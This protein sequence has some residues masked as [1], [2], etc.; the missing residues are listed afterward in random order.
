MS[1][2]NGEN[3]KVLVTGGCGF[4]GSH[5]CEYY[6]NRGDSVIAYDS[7]TKYELERVGYGVDAS[8][9]YNWNF[10]EKLGVTMVKE[11]I[12]D[13]ETLLEH[14]QGVD[15]IIHTAAQPAMTISEEDPEL[16]FSTNVRG[17]FNVLK[18]ARMII[19]VW[20]SILSKEPKHLKK[21]VKPVLLCKKQLNVIFVSTNQWALPVK[22][23]A[24]MMP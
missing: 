16:D 20:L 23:H 18:V 19:F 2:Y 5:V 7:M 14:S 21:I 13:F 17:T 3:M 24:P 1:P 6:I 15:Y 22:E 4:L 9:D 11:D 8:R 12:R 10:L